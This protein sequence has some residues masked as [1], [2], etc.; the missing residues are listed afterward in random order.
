[1]ILKE[2][3]ELNNSYYIEIVEDSLKLPNTIDIKN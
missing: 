2:K 1:M 3:I